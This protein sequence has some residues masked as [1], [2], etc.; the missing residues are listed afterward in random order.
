MKI[1]GFS[2]SL[3]KDSFNTAALRAAQQLVPAGSALEIFSLAEIPIYNEDLRDKG[4]PASVQKFRDAIRAADAVLIACPEYNYSFSGVLKNAIDWASRPPEQPF[5]GKK[6]ALMGAS[7]GMLGTARAQY[8]LRQVFIFMNGKVLNRP[9]VFIAAA[10]KKFDD[11]GNLTDE[12]T[13]EVIGKLLTAL[14][15]A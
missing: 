10:D 6:I 3:R 13:R 12:K 14:I 8:Q 15:N 7:P 2:G 4:V 9:E 5:D 11:K 1:L